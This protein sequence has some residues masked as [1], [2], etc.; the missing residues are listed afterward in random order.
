MAGLAGMR[1]ERDGLGRR[2]SALE[3]SRG[4]FAGTLPRGIGQVWENGY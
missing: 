4:Q 3:G 2:T 1:V